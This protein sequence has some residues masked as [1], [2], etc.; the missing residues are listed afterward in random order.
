MR[1][2]AHEDS[3]CGTVPNV[4]VEKCQQ[5]RIASICGLNAEGMPEGYRRYIGI[6]MQYKHKYTGPFLI[7]PPTAQTASMRRHISRQLRCG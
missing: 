1:H 5:R 4:Y 3:G 6:V 2:P 7:P